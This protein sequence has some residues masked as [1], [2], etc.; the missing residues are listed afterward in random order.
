MG[1]FIL[2]SVSPGGEVAA[3]GYAVWLA[4]GGTEEQQQPILLCSV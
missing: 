3:T 1:R 4:V 2:E